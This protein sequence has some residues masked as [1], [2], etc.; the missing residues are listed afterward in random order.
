MSVS[1]SNKENFLSSSTSSFSLN[2]NATPFQPSQFKSASQSS[3]NLKLASQ[4]STVSR[5][6]A[7]IS[8]EKISDIPKAMLTETS[9]IFNPENGFK[10]MLKKG[11]FKIEVPEIQELANRVVPSLPKGTTELKFELSARGSDATS[12]AYK[13]NDIALVALETVLKNVGIDREDWGKISCNCTYDEGNTEFSVKHR[14]F[15]KFNKLKGYVGLHILNDSYLE[16]KMGGKKEERYKITAQKGEVIVSMGE[17]LEIITDQKAPLFRRVCAEKSG[18]YVYSATMYPQMKLPKEVVEKIS[19]KNA[20]R[21]VDQPTQSKNSQT[22]E[23]SGWNTENN[24]S[25][26]EPSWVRV[27]LFK[28]IETEEKNHHG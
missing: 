19:H 7:R 17:L 14:E 6:N 28:V 11:F 23:D 4:S 27:P 9:I 3:T 20:S 13:L 16:V 26:K 2:P 1:V 22:S 18:S 8:D 25:K 15:E 24:G 5:S 12:L 21:K 10:E